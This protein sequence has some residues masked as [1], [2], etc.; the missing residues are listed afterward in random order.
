[1][2]GGDLGGDLAFVD[3]LVGQH[4]LTHNIADGENAGHVGPHLRI[5]G[6]EAARVDNHPGLVRA[7]T[8]AVG[9]SADRSQNPVEL[10]LKWAIRPFE[11]DHEAGLACIDPGDL[12]PQQILSSLSIRFISG[13][14]M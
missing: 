2:A 12:R 8:V 5:D 1:M 7:D 4:R 13:A 10:T 6:D 11:R 3:G 14:T 9:F